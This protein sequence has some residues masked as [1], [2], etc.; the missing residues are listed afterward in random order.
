MKPSQIFLNQRILVPQPTQTKEGFLGDVGKSGG[1][2]VV[3]PISFSP[4]A[5][6]TGLF[7]YSQ[8]AG[9][10]VLRGFQHRHH[11]ADAQF[12]LH[13]EPHKPKAQGFVEHPVKGSEVGDCY[14]LH[15][16]YCRQGGRASQDK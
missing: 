1:E 13:Q 2:F 15:C 8:M 5:H 12:P 3:N 16:A 14:M 9:D 7:K 11:F 4:A 6:K 10:L